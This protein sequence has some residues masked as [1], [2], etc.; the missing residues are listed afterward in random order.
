MRGAFN[1]D[2]LTGVRDVQKTQDGVG[3]LFGGDVN[4]LV[5]ALAG[6]RI[7]DLSVVEPDLEE[8][9]MHYYADGGE[10]G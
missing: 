8:V 3:F 5:R 7:S 9:F 1:P 6:Q 2:G 10:V 4:E